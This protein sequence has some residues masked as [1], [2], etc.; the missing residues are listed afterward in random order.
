[1]NRQIKANRQ[2]ESPSNTGMRNS[3]LT[4]GYL[5]FL[6]SDDIGRTWWS[7]VADTA[8]Q[9]GANLICF[10]G[11]PLHDPMDPSTEPTAVYD[12]VSRERVDG[13]VIGNIVADTPAS[14]ARL[15][16]LLDRQ[17]GPA[18]S[19]LRELRQGIPYVSMD[20]YRGAWAAIAHLV[21][22]HGY[23]RVACLRGPETHP[24][25]QERYRAYINVLQKNGLS[26][27]PDLVTPPH[28]WSGSPIKVLLD[29]RKLRPGADFD[30][31]VSA[32]DLM[33]LDAMS[34]LIARD[35][36]IPQDVAIIGFNNNPAAEVALPPLTTVTIPFHEQ[37]QRAVEMLLTLLTG[38]S[39]PDQASLP[40][41][42][43]VRQ[44][45]GCQLPLVTQAA[46][47]VCA[48]QHEFHELD[49]TRQ[50]Q[51][52]ASVAQAAENESILEWAR[53]ILAGLVAE[54]QDSIPGTFLREMDQ[55]MHPLMLYGGN[56]SVGQKVLS[57]LRRLT[58]PYMSGEM[59][60]RAEDLWHQAEV[61]LSLM[62]QQMHAS[63]TLQ[64]QRQTRIVRGIGHALG[65]AFD[66]TQIMDTLARELPHLNIPSCYVSLY[67][68]PQTP[69]AWSRLIMAYNEGGRV[70]LRS[71][72]VRF[73]SCK[74]LPDDLWPQRQ[75][76]LV[77]EPLHFQK[78]QLGFIVFEAGPRDGALYEMLGTQISSALHG[79]LLVQE[80]KQAQ[81]A[82]EKAYTEVEQQVEERTA[83]LWREIAERRRVEAQLERNLHETRVRFEVSQA[84]A[85]Q[86]TEDE[87]LDALIQHAGLY[88]QAFVSIV[89]LDRTGGE[90]TG[91]VR[92]RNA[93]ESG[94]GRVLPAN[95]RFPASH[96]PQLALSLS[97]DHSF[98]WNDILAD[99]K[100]DPSFRERARRT[101][102]GSFAAIPLTV[103]N[104]WMGL[105][106]VSAK[107]T[108]YF[109]EEKQHLYQT[110]AEQGAVALR[111]ARLRETIRASQQRLSLLVQQSPLAV[112][113]W[114]TDYRVMAW[115]PAAEKIF[116]Y[117][118]EQV[119]GHR[120][121]ELIVV[122]EE[123]PQ[124]EQEWQALL[125]QEGGT[126]SIKDNLTQTGRRITCEWFNAPLVSSDGRVIGVVS[127]VEDITE[128]KNA[129]AER[130]K[131][132]SD[133]EAR[134]AELE[135][136]TYTVSHD[137]K[138]PLV[139]I[140]GFLGH[141]EKD[142][143][144]GNMGRF[145][146]DMARI[147]EATD[148]MQRLLNEL[149]SLSRIGRMKNPSQTAPFEAIAREAVE[150]VHGRIEAHGVQVSIAPD[151]PTVYGDRARLVEVVQNLVDNACKFMGDQPDPRVEIG[152]R[153]T[154]A[155]GKPILFVRDNGIGI[156]SQ[157]HERVFGLFNKLDA[158]TEGTG[159]GL[160]LVKRIVEFHGGRIWVESEGTGKGSTFYFTLP[161]SSEKAGT[162]L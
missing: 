145:T 62:V 22:E 35:A 122:E 7:G 133:L 58:L 123:R 54:L 155:D 147:V 16:D 5:A 81:A 156:E 70:V 19:S 128:R 50:E 77:V 86:E 56:L 151:L 75:F 29:D 99:E 144:S 66:T 92:R 60:A 72:R 25:A 105:I 154:D 100:I 117:T 134:N 132:I 79:A 113:E 1:M 83:E 46:A 49:L 63:E 125:A 138:S 28:D 130:E 37:G 9:Q 124:V 52:L 150:L 119:L 149:L 61:M 89:T 53:Q 106:F 12:L 82:L 146:A 31:I 74:L 2:S 158:K 139:T 148:K 10:R 14:F 90:L 160:A 96:H 162:K 36:H 114:D 32:N 78:K 80:L 73:P 13:C 152:Q 71:D 102:T 157:Y 64:A 26:F 69:A 85:G 8:W 93:F 141:M 34:Q 104:E 45:C 43:I 4:I 88:P 84:L 118:H 20:N 109:G 18:V 39:L 17:L 57:A 65:S 116:G 67:E 76:C 51:I 27:D 137:L 3:R 6:I 48:E 142:A 112:I 135:R 94:L 68:D 15:Q 11:G 55:A 153:G 21:E 120:A 129:E 33:A 161:D 127:L 38:G 103:G 140:R 159:V 24:Y 91:I 30:A 23:R 97:A 40:A 98:V 87:V 136:F 108:G 111:A 121:T 44:S 107:L 110:L 41:Q 126:H 42:L 59:L 115:N 47:G 131:L 143:R 95:V 101:G